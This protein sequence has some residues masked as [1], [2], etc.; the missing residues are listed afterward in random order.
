MI[1]RGDRTLAELRR[2]WDENQDWLG[3][4]IDRLAPT[5]SAQLFSYTPLPARQ[6]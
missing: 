5:V 4:C 1:P 6:V 3:S 2:L